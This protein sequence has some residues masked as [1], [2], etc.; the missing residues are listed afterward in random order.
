MAATRSPLRRWDRFFPVFAAIDGAIEDATGH[1]RGKFR[2]V[3][4]R[5][6]T[7]L[8]AARDDDSGGGGV[9]EELCAVLDAVPGVDR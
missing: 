2:S 9:A 3:R 6:V 1:P 7:L 4:A 5:I 8:R